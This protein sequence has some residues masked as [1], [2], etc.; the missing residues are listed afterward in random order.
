M[1]QL[2]PDRE[3]SGPECV[4][5]KKLNNNLPYQVDDVR[6]DVEGVPKFIVGVVETSKRCL[7]VE[8]GGFLPV[9]ELFE[10]GYIH[11][12]ILE[13]FC[14]TCLPVLSIDVFR[15]EKGYDKT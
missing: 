15:E 6:H 12:I 14:K 4:N 8:G 10:A 9:F 7:A 5:L 11:V 1:P 2:E 3:P 13:I